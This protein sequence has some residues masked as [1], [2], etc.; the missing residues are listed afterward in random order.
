MYK[1]TTIIHSNPPINFNDTSREN[2]LYQRL[3]LY[4]PRAQLNIGVTF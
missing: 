3:F 1:Y 2:W 4:E